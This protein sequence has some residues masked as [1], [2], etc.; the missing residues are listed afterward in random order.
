MTNPVVVLDTSMG[1]IRVALDAELAPLTVENFVGYVTRG[2]YDGTVFHRVIPGFMIQGGGMDPALREKPTRPPIRNEAANGLANLRGS[3]AMA[4][5]G[6][7]DSATSQFF[8]NVA[9]NGFLNHRDNSPQGFGYAVFGQVIEGMDVV[10][11]I[12]GVPTARRGPHDDVPVEPVT[13]LAARVETDA[14]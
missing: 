13:I 12:V 9:D 4:R 5:T 7:V 10:D 11:A 2:H 3:L 14:A 1:A 8:I 6:V